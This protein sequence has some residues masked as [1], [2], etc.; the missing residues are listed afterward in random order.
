[1]VTFVAGEYDENF[2]KLAAMPNY[3]VGYIAQGHMKRGKEGSGSACAISQW[4]RDMFAPECHPF[5]K[6][7]LRTGEV[8]S[9]V[10]D[11]KAK[12]KYRFEIQGTI[13]GFNPKSYDNGHARPGAFLIHVPEVEPIAAPKHRPLRTP[14]SGNKPRQSP[15]PRQWLNAVA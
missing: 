3:T 9:V 7:D 4:C 2:K 10:Y 8:K 5:T 11:Y 1:M 13:G 6:Q 12:L 14:P 15:R